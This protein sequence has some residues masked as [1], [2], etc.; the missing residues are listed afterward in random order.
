MRRTY[1]EF[2]EGLRA[3]DRARDAARAQGDAETEAECGGRLRIALSVG[4][5]PV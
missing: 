1:L 5:I 4:G 2:E 3:L